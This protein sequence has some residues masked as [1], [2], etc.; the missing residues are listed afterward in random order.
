MVRQFKLQNANGQTF[1]LM[2]RDAFFYTPDGLGFTMEFSRFS[3][4]DRKEGRRM[5]LSHA[6]YQRFGVQ[7]AH[8]ID[9][10]FS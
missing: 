2:Q 8:V 7:L 3:I 4:Y 9:A 10:F 1:D 5:P 6:R